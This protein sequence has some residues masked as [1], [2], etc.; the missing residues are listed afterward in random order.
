MNNSI[1]TLADFFLMDAKTLSKD[2]RS[3]IETSSQIKELKKNLQK[4]AKSLKWS[5]ILD[6]VADKIA[7]LLNNITI[8]DIMLRAWNKYHYLDKYLDKSKYAPDETILI[9]LVEHTIKS[10]HHP[11]IEILVNDHVV[12]SIKLD[13]VVAF[14]LKGIMLTIK[15][16]KIRQIQTGTCK[17]SGTVKYGQM[18]LAQ[19]ELDTISLPGKIN[20]DDEDVVIG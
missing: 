11:S 18:I 17:I 8:K 14:K 15:D 9:P 10:K 19:K 12:D 20:L 6:Q 2:Q 13:I 5:P 7:D 1:N 4:E 3:S 16:G